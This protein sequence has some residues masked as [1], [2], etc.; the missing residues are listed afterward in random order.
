MRK[1]IV[2]I[3]AFGVA[4]PQLGAGGP[5]DKQPDDIPQFKV[6]RASPTRPATPSPLRRVLS[7]PQ[8]RTLPDAYDLSVARFFENIQNLA[9]CS[10]GLFSTVGGISSHSTAPQTS[11]NP[12]QRTRLRAKIGRDASSA[13]SAPAS[14]LSISSAAEPMQYDSGEVFDGFPGGTEMPEGSVQNWSPLEADSED[15]TAADEAPTQPQQGLVSAFWSEFM[16]AINPVGF[17]VEEASSSGGVSEGLPSAGLPVGEAPSSDTVSAS[18]PF[19]GFSS[20]EGPLVASLAWPPPPV[21]VAPMQGIG[22][23]SPKEEL[24]QEALE[25]VM[26]SVRRRG[27]ALE[28]LK[29]VILFSLSIVPKGLIRGGPGRIVSLMEAFFAEPPGE[30]TKMRMFHI[31]VEWIG[32]H[33]AAEPH[34]AAEQRRLLYAS[35]ACWLECRNGVFQAVQFMNEEC[36]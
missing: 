18:S 29:R 21:S 15:P 3:V 7:S 8:R 9:T 12:H 10:P 23:R 6:R 1:W 13:S 30:E 25:H 27:S 33:V 34:V 2:A 22:G 20:G 28:N 5:G 24:C 36:L 32:R 14:T 4:S 26:M 11:L 16:H 17:N 35:V 19:G 31:Y